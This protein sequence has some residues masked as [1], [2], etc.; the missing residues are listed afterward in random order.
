M[1]NAAL[2]LLELGLSV[3]PILKHNK[4]TPKGCKWIDQQDILP[5][6]AKTINILYNEMLTGEKGEE[7]DMKNLG[8]II[9]TL[10]DEDIDLKLSVSSKGICI[11]LG[12]FPR[13]EKK[14]F[15]DMQEGV[16]WLILQISIYFPKVRRKIDKRRIK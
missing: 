11:E 3:V 2:E 12:S 15:I 14:K 16:D 5:E 8:I 7:D 9:N 13:R 1:L 4:I 6:Y 10:F